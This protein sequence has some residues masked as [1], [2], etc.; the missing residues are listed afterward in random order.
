MSKILRIN[1][2]SED[3]TV[4]DLRTLFKGVGVIA[5]KISREKVT[6]ASRGFGFV[7]I[8]SSD[9]ARSAISSL[10]GHS[11]KG[12]SIRVVAVPSP[13]KDIRK[14]GVRRTPPKKS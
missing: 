9:D 7:K 8:K 12:K 13:A 2:L 1:N 3:T 6:G 10:N 5:A 4:E 11:L 14:P